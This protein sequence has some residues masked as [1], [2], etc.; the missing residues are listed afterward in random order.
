MFSL[1]MNL[2]MKYYQ[3][4]TIS[5]RISVQCKKNFLIFQSHALNLGLSDALTE[6]R[7]FSGDASRNA[8]FSSFFPSKLS[9]KKFE[10]G[11]WGAYL[12]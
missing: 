2:R 5:L 4:L 12:N 11:I 6:K 8:P 7:D 1:L 9:R 3:L 10:T